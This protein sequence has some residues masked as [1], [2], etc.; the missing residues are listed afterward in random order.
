VQGLEVDRV[1]QVRDL[2]EAPLVEQLLCQLD[3]IVGE[4]DL[5]RLLVD[6]VVLV[7]AQAGDDLVDVWRTFRWPFRPVR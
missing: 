5:P 1:V 6:D 4:G 7:Q 2:E 3:A